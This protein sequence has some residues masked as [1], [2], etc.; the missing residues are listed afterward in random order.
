MQVLLVQSLGLGS[1]GNVLS[2]V[3]K[4]SL[5]SACRQTLGLNFGFPFAQGANIVYAILLFQLVSS[6]VGL[7]P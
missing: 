3:G 5:T 2:S 1:V 4:E 7:V 6:V